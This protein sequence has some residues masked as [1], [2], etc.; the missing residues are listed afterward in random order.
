MTTVEADTDSFDEFDLDESAIAHIDAV[1]GAL[2][3]RNNGQ[4]DGNAD[5]PMSDA[6]TNAW[7]SK[8]PSVA[9]RSGVHGSS[10]ANG[11]GSNGDRRTNQG[12]RNASYSH[13]GRGPEHGGGEMDAGPSASRG[14]PLI[15]TSSGPLPP[16]QYVQRNL[17]GEVAQSSAS[18]CLVMSSQARVEHAGTKRAKRTKQWERAD[19]V[20]SR[21]RKPMRSGGLQKTQES[22]DLPDP[23][24][25]EEWEERDHHIGRE[26][27]SGQLR[28]GS[29]KLPP[30]SMKLQLDSRAAEKFIYPVN[31]TKRDYQ[32]NIVQRA[33]YDNVLVALPTGLGK[34]FIAAVVILN[35]FHWYPQ[36]KIVFV[37]PTRPLVNQQQMACHGI[38]GLPWDLA[39]EMTGNT[40]RSRRGD[41]WQEKRIFYMTP[42]TLDNDLRTGDVDPK[43][44]VCLVVDEAHRAT[45]NYAYCN[46]VAQIQAVNPYFRI[47]ALTATPGSTAER[48]QEVIDNLHISLIELRTE[49]AL[50]I[51]QYVHKKHEE[52]IIVQMTDDFRHIR[53]LYLA[54]M[55]DNCEALVKHGLL[56][57]ADPSTLH[58]FRVRSVYAERRDIIA[59]KR[60]LGATIQETARMAEAR[61]HLDVFSIKMF[62]GRVQ[63]L[64]DSMKKQDAKKMKL[65]QILNLAASIPDQAHPK[66]VAAVDTIISHFNKEQQQ[67]NVSSRVM[68]FCSLRECVHEIVELLNA[69]EG[70]KA[71]SFIGQSADKQGRGLTQKQQKEIIEKFKKGI[72]NVIVATSIGEEGLDIGEVDLIV[73]YEAVKDSVR[74][75]QRV[76]RTGRKRDGRIVVL[77]SEGPESSIWQKSKDTYKGVQQTINAGHSVT[78]FD[79]VPRL[80]PPSIRPIPTFEELDQPDF[81][82][83]FIGK[84]VPLAAKTAR[85]TEK[86]KRRKERLTDVKRNA[87][88]GALMGFLRASSLTSKKGKS[89]LQEGDDEDLDDASGKVLAE[90]RRKD[91][92]DDS[93]DEALERGLNFHRAH[94]RNAS[95]DERNAGALPQPSDNLKSS[96]SLMQSSLSS[97]KRGQRLGVRRPAQRL[98]VESSDDWSSDDIEIVHPHEAS[99]SPVPQVVEATRCADGLE[100]AKNRL[101]PI[102]DQMSRARQEPES[103]ALNS[104]QEFD[105]SW[106]M[107]SEAL[108]NLT[109]EVVEN[110][111]SSRESSPEVYRRREAH[112][113]VASLAAHDRQIVQSA[114]RVGPGA[115][116]DARGLRADEGVHNV[117]ESSESLS[118]SRD[119]HQVDVV[120]TPA[121]GVLRSALRTS[122]NKEAADSPIVNRHGRRPLKPMAL[123][124][125]PDQTPDLS[126]RKANKF[127]SRAFHELSSDLEGGNVRP[128]KRVLAETAASKHEVNVKKARKRQKLPKKRIGNSPT[129]RA[130]FRFEADRDTDEERRGVRSDSDDEGANTD[131][132]GSS[133]LEHVGDFQPTQAPRGYNQKSVYQQSLLTQGAPTP[134]RRKTVG[135]FVGGRY[136]P[137]STPDSHE[138]PR[139]AE[140]TRHGNDDPDDTYSVG[141]FVCD[142]DEIEYASDNGLSDE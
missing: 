72:V 22:D 136:G 24:D 140:R 116:S 11:H 114:E 79:D 73:C 27:S 8:D 53:D 137:P 70:L 122:S 21:C 13:T 40:S 128:E 50:D 10:I 69:N 76:G 60:W 129:S 104:S 2:L 33:L 51:R 1:A 4:P 138:G 59:K 46:I 42:Q 134:F 20:A 91:L 49:E 55:Q 38:C 112:P 12:Q 9:K 81:R 115:T 120:R 117:A 133:D 106:T 132:A 100:S 52:T 97:R 37:A 62:R 74:M 107:D 66:M 67:G 44:I 58:P 87:P 139:H 90:G 14:R 39:C 54:V 30:D 86:A 77:M 80:I 26:A 16:T 113:L 94:Q 124:S 29:V 23:W 84:K 105:V 125:S 99:T 36:G 7:G 127:G 92:S 71:T 109:Q 47:L 18:G 101:P 126:E 119:L 65:A 89:R 96:T 43:D 56:P 31:M 88:E 95:D 123:T 93:D 98:A 15:R 5:T 82:P 32:F 111:A 131:S 75:L 78:L 110:R 85:V 130:L 108:A 103:K 57:N 83:D 118:Q 25:V 141:S 45:G 64:V 19:D 102:A 135:G 17:F 28:P 142:D 3:S 41:E 6:S 63:D 35:F 34:T 61:A 68:V 48:V 121:N